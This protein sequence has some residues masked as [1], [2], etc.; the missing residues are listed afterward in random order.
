MET[1]LKIFM[2]LQEKKFKE[3]QI[4]KN[5]I[6]IDKMVEKYSNKKQESLK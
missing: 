1:K 4:G 2:E 3:S 6:A 5:K